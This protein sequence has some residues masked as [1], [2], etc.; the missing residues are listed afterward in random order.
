MLTHR[1]LLAV[2]CYKHC[3][4]QTEMWHVIWKVNKV[5]VNK[6]CH[7]FL[8]NSGL[9]ALESIW[10][11]IQVDNTD[12]NSCISSIQTPPRTVA[13]QSRGLSDGPQSSN[14]AYRISKIRLIITSRQLEVQFVQTIQVVYTAVIQFYSSKSLKF[15]GKSWHIIE[16][17]CDFT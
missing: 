16:Q 10:L 17:F 12:L 2:G 4:N 11:P 14:V 6:Q 8:Y 5:Y 13:A 15:L 9:I 7:K 1:S 3:R